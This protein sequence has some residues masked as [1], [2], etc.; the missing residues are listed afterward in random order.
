ML[1]VQGI[2]SAAETGTRIGAHSSLPFKRTALP[3]D[4]QR[5][6]R[7]AVRVETAHRDAGEERG[8]RIAVENCIRKGS[9]GLGQR[10]GY[11][12]CPTALRFENELDHFTRSSA[13]AVPLC[14]EVT[15]CF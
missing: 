12:F 14:D 5:A 15:Y 3:C 11:G 13:P 6:T 10:F 9:L 2:T 7:H 4:A 8:D 1:Y